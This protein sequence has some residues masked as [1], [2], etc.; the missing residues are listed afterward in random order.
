MAAI[1]VGIKPAI[2]RGSAVN[3][4]LGGTYRT[5]INYNNAANDTGTLTSG[6]VWCLNAGTG[7]SLKIGTFSDDGG[8]VFTCNDGELIGEVAAGSEVTWSGTDLD[9]NSGEFIGG[10]AR[11][12]TTLRVESDTSGFAGVWYVTG[13]LC[14]ATDTDT[15]TEQA[16]D[17]MSLFADGATA[18]VTDYPISTTCGLTASATVAYKAAWD[19]SVNAGLM[20]SATVVKGWGRTITTSAGLTAAVTILKGWGRTIA[21]TAGLTVS[22]IIL[23]GWGRKI[24]TSTGLTIS[25]TIAKKVAY[26]RSVVADLVIGVSISVT[27]VVHYLVAITTNLVVSATVLKGWGRTIATSTGLTAAVSI[28]ITSILDWIV[29]TLPSRSLAM[30]L[31]SRSLA[32]TLKVRSLAMTL[33]SRSLAMTLKVRSIIMTLFER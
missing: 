33:K 21:T 30:T 7:S 28:A 19:R 23:K 16:D 29:L 2:D 27:K 18:G 3:L 24:A 17:G 10:D 4:K 15:F 26:T 14:D 20:S 12:A 32:M 8:G 13:T 6:G 22:V 9:V 1:D 25:T 11:S 5:W 31:Q